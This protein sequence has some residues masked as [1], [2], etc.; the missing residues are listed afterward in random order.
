[1]PFLLYGSYRAFLQL[2]VLPTVFPDVVPRHWRVGWWNRR[3]A[4]RAKPELKAQISVVWF[5]GDPRFSGVIAAPASDEST[6][7][8]FRFVSSANTL[9]VASGPE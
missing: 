1:M 4:P 6:P 8:R 3:M 2:F 5:A 7:R 9:S